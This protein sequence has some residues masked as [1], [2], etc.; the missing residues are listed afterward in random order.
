MF[1]RFPSQIVHCESVDVRT[2]ICTPI[3]LV[4]CDSAEYTWPFK[5]KSIEIKYDHRPTSVASLGTFRALI[6]LVG[7]GAPVF[8]IAGSRTSP[9]SQEVLLDSAAKAPQLGVNCTLVL[10]AHACTRTGGG[11]GSREPP[12]RLLLSTRPR[13]VDFES[14]RS[15]PPA[16][17]TGCLFRL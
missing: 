13:V 2:D 11:G 7:L 5:F 4:S 1:S 10:C 14:A 9:S 12:G 17:L 6:S 8:D 16:I 3:S 15:A